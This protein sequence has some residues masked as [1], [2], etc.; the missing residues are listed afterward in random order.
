MLRRYGEQALKEDIA[1]VLL[2]WSGH[3]ESSG[4]IVIAAPKTIRPSLF[5]AA[6]PVLD[7]D[8]PRIAFVPFAVDKPTLESLQMIHS[9][10]TSILF[11]HAADE[12]RTEGPEAP[13]KQPAD[14][15]A[16]FNPSYEKEFTEEVE[17]LSLPEDASLLESP[18]SRRLISACESGN[19]AELI[20]I[21]EEAASKEPSEDDRLEIAVNLPDSLVEMN[22]P[23][24]I[25]AAKG[26]AKAVLALLER[27]ANPCQLDVRG[28]PPYFL[29]KDKEVRD[30]FRRYRGRVEE[31]AA[32]EKEARDGEGEE[33][34]GEEGDGV[35]G[36]GR[37]RDWDWAA[38]GV[39]SALTDFLEKQQRQKEKEKKKRAQQRKKE[40]KAQEERAAAEALQQL[41]R[42]Q[43]EEELRR[44]KVRAEA[45]NC[46]A[47]GTQLFGI[48]PIQVSD[49]PLFLRWI[50]LLMAVCP[51]VLSEK[52]CSSACVVRVRR[53]LAAEAALKRLSL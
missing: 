27:G 53:S 32:V 30:A 26:M 43:R 39:G 16:D 11:S 33:G 50:I 37:L 22:S 38:A 29:A 51:Q 24:H 52:C 5:E 14:Q 31:Q 18:L 2:L 49:F 21:L 20:L 41:A 28:R 23:L 13:E 40:Q 6:S 44:E 9:R 48:V 19:E 35:G 8:D 4:S 7:K 10:C 42:Q 17:S 46:S 1:S 25:A 36:R 3:I 47:C 12:E 34:D 45:G 15:T